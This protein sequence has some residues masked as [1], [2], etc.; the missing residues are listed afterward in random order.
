MIVAIVITF[1]FGCGIEPL[2]AVYNKNEMIAGIPAFLVGI[3]VVTGLLV[4]ESVIL[5]LGERNRDD[6]N[7]N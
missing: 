3:L 5:Y 1:L 4:V 6:E 7:G 2:M